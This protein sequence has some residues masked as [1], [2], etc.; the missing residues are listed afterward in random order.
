[1]ALLEVTESEIDEPLVDY[2]IVLVVSGVLAIV[3]SLM[4]NEIL[5]MF[6]VVATVIV[7]E[8]VVMHGVACSAVPIKRSAV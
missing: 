3:P 7:R 6:G 1:M 2:S 8:T 4:P 5:A